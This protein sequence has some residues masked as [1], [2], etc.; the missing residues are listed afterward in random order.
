MNRRTYGARL[1]FRNWGRGSSSNISI[2]P[3]K[4]LL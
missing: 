1:Q 3:L 4:V 2:G